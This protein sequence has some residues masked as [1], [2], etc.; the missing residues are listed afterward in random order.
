MARNYAA[1]RLPASGDIQQC[2]SLLEFQLCLSVSLHLEWQP[3]L[4]EK[5]LKGASPGYWPI[6]SQ[7]PG[8]PPSCDPF[9][10]TKPSHVGSYSYE[11]TPCFGLGKAGLVGEEQQAEGFLEV[12]TDGAGVSQVA[13]G[14]GARRADIQPSYEVGG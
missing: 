9:L 8:L 6:R 14:A 2:H 7:S 10:K 4:T 3:V 11:R 1:P 5:G 13:T 12:G